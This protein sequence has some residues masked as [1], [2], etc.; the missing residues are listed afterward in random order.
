MKS[1]SPCAGL[2]GLHGLYEKQGPCNLLTVTR[3]FCVTLGTGG[4]ITLIQNK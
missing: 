2:A 4:L 3:F 1:L